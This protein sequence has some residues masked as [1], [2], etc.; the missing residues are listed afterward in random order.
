MQIFCA[1]FCVLSAFY[2][3]WRN[4]AAFR[5]IKKT[6]PFNAVYVVGERIW[7]LTDVA[8]LLGLST[9]PRCKGTQK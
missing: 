3:F 4:F 1:L 2:L 7:F 5:I 8:S 6:A 9:Y